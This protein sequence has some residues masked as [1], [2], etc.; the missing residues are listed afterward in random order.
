M[1]PLSLNLRVTPSLAIMDEATRT[2]LTR[3]RATILSRLPSIIRS[4]AGR[5]VGI[6]GAPR[7]QEIQ[8]LP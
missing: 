8:K 2:Q 5:Q 4:R 3:E 7:A 1:G 6:L